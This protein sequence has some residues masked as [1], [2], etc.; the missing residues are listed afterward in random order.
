MTKGSLY[1]F[2]YILMSA[3]IFNISMY[4]INFK[5]Y[6]FWYLRFLTLNNDT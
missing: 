2:M 5:Y 1:V 4:L 3:Y 6:S